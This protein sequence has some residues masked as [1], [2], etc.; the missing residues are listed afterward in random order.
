MNK[1][2]IEKAK[3]EQRTGNRIVYEERTPEAWGTRHIVQDDRGNFYDLSTRC[4]MLRVNTTVPAT[5]K[6]EWCGRMRIERT[7]Q[8]DGC[9]SC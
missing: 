8:C 7:R 2:W 3:I 6:C 9:G 1:S 5:H 4:G